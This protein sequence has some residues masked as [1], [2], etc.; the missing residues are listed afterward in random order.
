LASFPILALNLVRRAADWVPPSAP[1]GESL[2]IDG[3]PGATELTLALDGRVVAQTALRGEV[4]EVR[5]ARP[6]VYTVMET[7]PGIDRHGGRGVILS[8]GWA[9]AS[10]RDAVG[11]EGWSEST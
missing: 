10:A 7:G 1:A 9:T 11:G 5:V 2:P 6:G 4:E 3:T 8:D